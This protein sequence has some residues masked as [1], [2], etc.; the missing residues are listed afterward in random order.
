MA[1]VATFSK[2]KIDGAAHG[3]SCSAFN[4]FPLPACIPKQNINSNPHPNTKPTLSPT[5]ILRLQNVSIGEGTWFLSLQS[6]RQP[7]A[8]VHTR[9]GG[10][11]V[12]DDSPC[13]S[14]LWRR[15]AVCPQLLL[16][17]AAHPIPGK[18]ETQSVN[19]LSVMI[20]P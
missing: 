11:K 17:I 16:Q 18:A 5:S 7:H 13:H 10:N 4:D 15:S 3:L 14:G 12:T 20:Q 6:V 1:N 2:E 8:H 19:L 9:G